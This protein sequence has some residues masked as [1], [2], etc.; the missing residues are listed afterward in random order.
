MW[1]LIEFF[2]KFI[3]LDRIMTQKSVAKGIQMEAATA[4]KI[5]ATEA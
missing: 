2:V 4:A 3:S 5:M 1:L